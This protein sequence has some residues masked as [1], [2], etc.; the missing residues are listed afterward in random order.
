M[1]N[2]P[3]KNSTILLDRKNSLI[4]IERTEEDIQALRDR[5]IK[6][7]RFHDDGGEPI[8]YGKYSGFPQDTHTMTVKVTGLRANWSHWNKKPKGLCTGWWV[9][10]DK[11]IIFKML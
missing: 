1:N 10:G 11:E 2:K 3:K 8:L 5:D 4:W 6:A 7:G 9:E